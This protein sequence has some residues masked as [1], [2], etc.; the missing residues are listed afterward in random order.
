MNVLIEDFFAGFAVTQ[1]T[2]IVIG[3]W[4]VFLGLVGGFLWFSGGQGYLGTKAWRRLGVPL[5]ICTP[6]FW[7]TPWYWVLASGLAQFGVQSVGYGV[8]DY[9]DPKGSFLGRIFGKWTRVVWYVLM[10]IALIPLFLK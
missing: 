10:L 3:P 4:S 2:A 5:V 7:H 1:I 6:F 9:N 8:P